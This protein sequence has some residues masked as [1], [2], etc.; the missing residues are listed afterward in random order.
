MEP[1][2][3]F[4]V[5]FDAAFQ[6]LQVREKISV[7]QNNA[8]WLGRRS[9]SV[10]NFCNGVSGGC[11]TRIRIRG[12]RRARDEILEIVDDDRGWRAEQLHLLTIAQDELHA[13][14][15]DRAL[16]E[17]WRRGGVHRHNHSAPQE[18]SPVTSDPFG[19]IGSP[20]KNSITWSN[21]VPG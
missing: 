11:I 12:R 17:I 14:I 6:R 19:R 13:G 5:L 16:N 10:K 3:V 1:A 9:R 2:L 21:P 15:L 18:D 8:A 20:E 7:G 4:P